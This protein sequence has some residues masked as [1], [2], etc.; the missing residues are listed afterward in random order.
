MKHRIY[1]VGKDIRVVD[2]D[3]WFESA[4]FAAVA[5]PTAKKDI[6]K[7]TLLDS[8]LKYPQDRSLP[9]IQYFFRRED[10][11]E[12]IDSRIDLSLHPYN[13]AII[14]APA[15]FEIEVSL[16]PNTRQFRVEKLINASIK[17]Y[18]LKTLNHSLVENDGLLNRFCSF[19]FRTKKFFCHQENFNGDLNKLINFEAKLTVAW[20]HVHEIGLFATDKD[21]P[22]LPKELHKE[23]I[24]RIS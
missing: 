19:F 8:F 20:I 12:Y 4:F 23:I 13:Q 22:A 3:S 14:D 16:V 11:I 2:Y 6:D 24:H 17:N 7:E 18:P 1:G 21:R 9:G 5:I 15:L 10:A